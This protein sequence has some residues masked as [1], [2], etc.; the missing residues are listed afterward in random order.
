MRRPAIDRKGL[1]GQE[2]GGVGGQKEGS[3]DEVVRAFRAR[4]ALERDDSLLLLGRDGLGAARLAA[5][6]AGESPAN[7]RVQTLL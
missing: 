1:A 6:P 3:A 4:D 2:R 5:I 7:R